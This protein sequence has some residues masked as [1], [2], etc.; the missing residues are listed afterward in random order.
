M[1]IFNKKNL[2]IFIFLFTLLI[3]GCTSSK[4]ISLNDAQII[5]EGYVEQENY[6]DIDSN[7]LG[8]PK[9]T[10]VVDSDE[11][12]LVKDSEVDARIAEAER[13]SLAP[14]QIDPNFKVE[15]PSWTTKLVLDPDAFTADKYVPKP[16]IISYKHKFE[17]VFR[18]KPRWRTAKDFE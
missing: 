7:E 13:L 18:S 4:A 6:A 12:G 9:D 2:S 8:L 10:E 11:I 16:P 1:K 5:R 3:N 15:D 14:A 17:K